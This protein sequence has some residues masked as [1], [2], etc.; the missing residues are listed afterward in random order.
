MMSLVHRKRA[1]KDLRSSRREAGTSVL[2][3]ALVGPLLMLVL[4]GMLDIGR[5]VFLV[6]EVNSAARAGAQYGGQNRGTALDTAGIQTAAK[7]DVPDIPSLAV[8]SSSSTCWCS[9]AP[10]TILS[11]CTLSSCTTT[12]STANEMIPLL[13]VNT[14][15]TYT[16]WIAFG[17]FAKAPLSSITVKGQVTVPQGQ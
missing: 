14:Q 16:P 5:W 9:A 17:A 10:G 6:M 1:S 2:E 11:S 7:N 3:V 4:F 13:K 15:A 12:G 8:T